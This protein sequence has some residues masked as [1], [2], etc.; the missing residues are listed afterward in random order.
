M[1]SFD[2]SVCVNILMLA[3]VM[4]VEFKVSSKKRAEYLASA[5]PAPAD[6]LGGFLER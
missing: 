2:L 3:V 4:A 5:A 6:L 1:G